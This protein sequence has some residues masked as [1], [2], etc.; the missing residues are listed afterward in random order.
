MKKNRR[1]FVPIQGKIT[2]WAATEQ[3]AIQKSLA[4]LRSMNIPSQVTIPNPSVAV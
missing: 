3:E 1:Y 2:V 4:V